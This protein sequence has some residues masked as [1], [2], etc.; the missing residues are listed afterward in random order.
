MKYSVDASSEA[1]RDTP[2]FRR[3][4]GLSRDEKLFLLLHSTRRRHRHSAGHGPMSHPQGEQEES[5][6]HKK[7]DLEGFAVARCDHSKP[8]ERR[9]AEHKN[10]ERIEK[11]NGIHRFKM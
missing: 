10:E 1:P 2:S 5:E 9:H 8:E 11:V 4:S 3:F 7:D 6:R